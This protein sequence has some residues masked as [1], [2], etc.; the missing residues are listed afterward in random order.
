[1]TSALAPPSTAVS[2]PV[3]TAA[4]AAPPITRAT[5]SCCVV[6]T[7]PL[8]PS[9]TTIQHMLTVSGR[10]GQ[11]AGWLHTWPHTPGSPNSFPFDLPCCLLLKVPALP[12]LLSSVPPLW[13]CSKPATSLGPCWPLLY[14]R[15]HRAQPPL[16]STPP[17]PCHC[18]KPRLTIYCY[19]DCSF[20]PLPLLLSPQD[21]QHT[22]QKLCPVTAPS[23]DSSRAPRCPGDG[24]GLPRLSQAYLYFLEQVSSPL[25][26][27]LSLFAKLGWGQEQAHKDHSRQ[28]LPGLENLYVEEWPVRW[29][30]V[31]SLPVPLGCQ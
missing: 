11:W 13:P 20:L 18:P 5:S 14:S 30:R 4:S 10:Q 25:L 23:L 7:G 15:Y 17:A 19:K 29:D 2:P 3:A 12:G 31:R 16:S 24:D 9:S 28:G 26:A 22:P 1:M 21:S 27:L 8:A 6:T